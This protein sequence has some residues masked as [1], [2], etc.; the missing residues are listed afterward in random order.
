MDATI[1]RG[2]HKH[3]KGTSFE[4]ACPFCFE[5]IIIYTYFNFLKTYVT[6]TRKF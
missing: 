2:P 4:K 1:H 6:E 3:T 5:D